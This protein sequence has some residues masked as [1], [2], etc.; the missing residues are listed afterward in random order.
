M[1]DAVIRKKVPE[2]EGENPVYPV[3]LSPDSTRLPLAKAYDNTSIW[4]ITNGQRLVGP[5]LKHDK[6]VAGIRFSPN[7]GQLAT[8][9]YGRSVCIFNSR[10]GDQLINIEIISPSTWPIIPPIVWSNSDGQKNFAASE[11]HTIK[12][13]MRPQGPDSPNRGFS[14]TRVRSSHQRKVHRY[15]CIVFHPFP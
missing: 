5:P 4:N 10:N 15:L 14:V 6:L 11:N 3:D 8:S 7:G 9:G 2:V 13:F 1:W 12:S